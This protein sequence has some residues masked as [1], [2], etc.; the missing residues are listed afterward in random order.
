MRSIVDK[1]EFFENKK[2]RAVPDEGQNWAVCRDYEVCEVPESAGGAY[3]RAKYSQ[4]Q[5]DKWTEYKPLQDKPDLFLRFANLHEQGRSEGSAL[6]WARRYGL[7]GYTPR[8]DVRIGR[9]VTESLPSEV[10]EPRRRAE[11]PSWEDIRPALG[12]T[13][14][15]A[16]GTIEVFWE[17]VRRAAGV[18]AMYE[19]WL[20]R[21]NDFAKEVL[22][23]RS[24][25]IGGRVWGYVESKTHTSEVSYVD[26]IVQMALKG[27]YLQYCLPTAIYVVEGTVNDFCY[28]RINLG[29][30]WEDPSQVVD[31]WAFENL[32]GAMYLQM[33]WLMGFSGNTVRCDWCRRPIS[34]ERPSPDKKKTP[35]HKRFCG[36][37]HRAKWNYHYGTGKSSKG[38]R[39]KKREEKKQERLRGDS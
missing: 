16:D 35:D 13:A 31:V 7:L 10:S 14:V 21:D 23:K 4:D 30:N 38:A 39:K 9:P 8:E 18:F 6:D 12:Y 26:A 36:P 29:E 37:D 27:S 17:E 28:H 24:P 20:S 5:K 34:L 11:V 25:F 3:V 32:L 22:L 1:C 19:A 15:P 2:M 33:Y